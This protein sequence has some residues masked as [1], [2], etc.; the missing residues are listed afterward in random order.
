MNIQEFYHVSNKLLTSLTKVN[1]VHLSS[2]MTQ[3]VNG[4]ATSTTSPNRVNLE[5]Q[6]ERTRQE[7]IKALDE[8]IPKELSHTEN[9]IL[10]LLNFDS[11]LGENGKH[12]I[13][14]IVSNIRKKPELSK[15]ICSEY[16]EEFN[17]VYHFVN[18]FSELGKTF[19]KKFTEVSKIDGFKLFFQKEAEISDL[20]D[21]GKVATKWNQIIIAFALLTGENDRQIKIVSA[22]RG[23]LIL[24]LAAIGGIV[25]SLAKGLNEI[26]DVIIKSYEIKKHAL[27]LRKLKL[28]DLQD[29]IQNLE[30]KAKINVNDTSGRITK[31][32][33]EE[34][35]IIDEG[36]RNETSNAL[37]A[38]LRH[39]LRF[40]RKGGKIEILFADEVDDRNQ[41]KLLLDQKNLSL[42][43]A[44]EKLKQLSGQDDDIEL[45][46]PHENDENLKND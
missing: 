41:I 46:D 38:A 37:N 28:E 2:Q 44:E 42:L 23:S 30:N 27:E 3:L 25:Y 31:N 40:L 9:R 39:I 24:T 19:P 10:D 12:R 7:M 1:Y 6:L 17:R 33:I 35:P 13:N 26:M 16:Q 14:T 21:L 34:F 36:I 5:T 4:L 11:V 22:E 43:E 18:S 32:L 45:I 29:T 20:V 8:I 15:Q